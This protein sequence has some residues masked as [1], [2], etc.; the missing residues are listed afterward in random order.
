MDNNAQWLDESF[1]IT[2]PNHK[3][4]TA[5]VR[6]IEHLYRWLNWEITENSN[7]CLKTDAQTLEFRLQLKPDEEQTI[8]YTVH[9]S[10]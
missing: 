1:G 9:Y 10:W 4:E 3:T 6:V 8:T 5:E 2:L 7:T